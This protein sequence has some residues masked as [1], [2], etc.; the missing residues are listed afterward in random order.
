[1]NADDCGSVPAWRTVIKLELVAPI[2]DVRELRPEERRLLEWLLNHGTPAAAPFL[3]QLPMVSVVSRCGCGCPTIDLAVSGHA[4]PVSSPSTIL[5]D[6]E[7]VSPEGV[8]VGVIVHGR[9]GLISELEIYSMAGE[10]I[11]SLPR[12]VD[13]ESFGDG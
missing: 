9:E 2:S 4:A 8:R 10:A 11:F 12:I 1:M 6:A 13:L 5:A 3:E 7:G